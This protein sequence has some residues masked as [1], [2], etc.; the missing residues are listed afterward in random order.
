MGTGMRTMLSSTRVRRST[1]LFC[2][3]ARTETRNAP[4][5]K[6]IVGVGVNPEYSDFGDFD[7]DGRL[8]I[9]GVGGH[10]AAAQI[11]WGPESSR[12]TEPTAW[13]SSFLPQTENR[14]HFLYVLTRDINRDG[15][16]DIVIGGRVQGTESLEN[17]EGKP[18][19]RYSVDGGACRS[20]GSTQPC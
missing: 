12:V 19:R 11:F 9:V 17:M 3:Q 4:W 5:K 10:G 14:G 20:Q 18:T 1:P 16:P 8:D 7:G 6:V 15:A 13:T 2:I